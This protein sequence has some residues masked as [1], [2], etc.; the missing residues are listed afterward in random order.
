MAGNSLGQDLTPLASAAKE[1]QSILIWIHPQST[2]DAVA[3]ALAWKLTWEQAEKSVSIVCSA[4]MRAEYQRLTGL[5]TVVTEA[6]NRDLVMSFPYDDNI[7]DKVSYNV[8]E[9]TSQFELIVS[10]K[11]GFQPLNPT[12]IHFRQAGIAADMIVLFGFHALEELGEVYE[13]E[14]YQIDRAFTVAVTQSKVTP[15]AKFHITLQNEHFSYSEWT[16]FLLRQLQLGQIQEAA[17]TN[18]LQG[19]EYAT[20]RLVAV[21]NA[22]TFET[23]AQLMRARARRQPDNPA[24]ARLSSP[25]EE[26][27]MPNWQPQESFPV[28]VLDGD[29]LNDFPEL[30]ALDESQAVPMLPSQRAAQVNQHQ[31]AQAQQAPKQNRGP[32]API[33]QLQRRGNNRSNQKQSAPNSNELAQAMGVKRV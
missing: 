27:E 28:E 5:D 31:P 9:A 16:Y 18:L 3:A 6:G 13:K 29:E 11:N 30:P 2:Y 19:I 17:A 33:H 4:P 32:G 23:V 24:F 25:I 26:P 22:R 14:R 8:N 1:A 7:V 10:P 12:E 15:F 20:D 21:Q